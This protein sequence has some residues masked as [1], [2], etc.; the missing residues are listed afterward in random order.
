MSNETFSIADVKR[1][2]LVEY[3][4]KLGHKPVKI[5]NNDYWYLS[6]LREERTASFKINRKLNLWYDFGI[7]DGGSIIDFGLKYFK[8]SIADFLNTF[9][10]DITYHRGQNFS[11]HR[12]DLRKSAEEETSRI[13]LTDVRTLTSPALLAYLRNRSIDLEIAK[14]Y[15][16]E[17]DFQ[18]YNRQHT[19]IG[20]QNDTGGFELRNASFKGSSSPKFTTLLATA[21]EYDRLSVFE[22]FIDFLS[23]KTHM[24]RDRNV[25]K[26]PERQTDFLILNSLSFFEISRS[27][28]ERHQ[29][30]RLYLDH[31]KAGFT[32]TQK[33]L[34]LSPKYQ[35][36]SHLYNGFKDFNDFLTH[37]LLRLEQG[38][39]LG[40]RI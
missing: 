38:K 32:Q 34:H 5:L 15:C 6:P 21:S 24:E 4:E 28:M 14:K 7:G 11:F 40:K 3:L 10:V 9:K 23:Y 29:S 22:G 2:D 18:L 17:V 12:S 13:K 1:I 36:G 37:R 8:T 31:D 19:A 16:S 27:L 35:D 39:R 26:L 30:I 20:F 33:A 25:E